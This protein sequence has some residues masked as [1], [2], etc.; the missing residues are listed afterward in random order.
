MVI[1]M[2]FKLNEYN[3]NITQDELI[4]DLIEVAKRLERKYVSRNEYEKNGK[5]SAAPFI[6]TF[7]TWINALKQ[8]GLDVKRDK[9]FLIRI[10]DD[11]LLKDMKTVAQLLNKVSI[12]TKDYVEHGQYK[13]QTI[14]SR[15]KNWSEA[16]QRAKLKQTGFK[17]ITDEDLFAE[18]E[19]VWILKGKQPTTTDMKNGISKF[20]LNTYLRRFGGWRNA[21]QAF[22][23]YINSNIEYVEKQKSE[24]VE[25]QKEEQTLENLSIKNSYKR[26]TP[27]DINNRLRFKVLAR[28]NFKCCACGA[29]PAITPGV[30]LHVDH[31]T[32]WSK[33][34]ETEINNLRT[35][36][37]K[38]NFGKGDLEL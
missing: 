17:I 22:L 3:R 33:G 21:L 6:R 37:S 24:T 25:F 5:Y 30:L 18:I 35:L 36:C 31:I 15:F 32:P 9:A 7:G 34:G 29:S 1:L 11:D 38:C 8:A 19:R 16:L 14:L 13:V 20:S 10:P 12:S 27:R 2:E 26:R 4:E 23:K 28:D